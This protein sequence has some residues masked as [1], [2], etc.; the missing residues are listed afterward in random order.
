MSKTDLMGDEQF[1]FGS[2]LVI[3]NRMDTLLERELKEFGLTTKQWMLAV[4]VESLFD[5]A[6]TIKQ[7]AKEMGS[8]HQNIKQ[9]ALKL[10]EKGLLHLEKDKKDARVT[11]LVLAEERSGFW[12]KTQPKG[13]AFMSALFEELADEEKNLMRSGLQKIMQ[14]L[15]KMETMNENNE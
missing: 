9:V 15:N 4:V 14:N 5:E 2:L 13:A 8:S 10:E 11:R 3:T 1:I 12:E 6:P 7:V